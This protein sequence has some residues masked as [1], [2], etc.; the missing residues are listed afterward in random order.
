MSPLLPHRTL[1]LGPWTS[2]DFHFMVNKYQPPLGYHFCQPSLTSKFP[3]TK[4]SFYYWIKMKV[5]YRCNQHPRLLS[6]ELMKR[7]IILSGSDPDLLIKLSKERPG[8]PQDQ[9]DSNRL[10]AAVTWDCRYH[11]GAVTGLWYIA[12]K[13]PR[14][15]VWRKFCQAW[16]WKQGF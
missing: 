8:L 15:S 3:A 7:E 14:S 1:V 4:I 11:E 9:R 6:S 10:K 13:K 5:F 2:F 16:I 12:S